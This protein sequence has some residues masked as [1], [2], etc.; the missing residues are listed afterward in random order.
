MATKK[1]RFINRKEF[2][3]EFAYTA[4]DVST[5]IGSTMTS[6]G[7]FFS[8][9]MASGGGTTN[10]GATI[11]ED[12]ANGFYNSIGL[13]YINKL[14]QATYRTDEF[15]GDGTSAT[16]VI[17]GGLV[18]AIKKLYDSGHIIG[19]NTMLN[20]LN[21]AKEFLLNHLAETKKDLKTKE[22]FINLATVS[23]KDEK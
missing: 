2:L 23:T 4:K 12:L 3:E 15:A 7:D 11:V 17:T 20:S 9:S 6:N 16:A 13:D 22:D 5:K 19:T 8:I 18:V 10:D 1:R 21:E 14:R